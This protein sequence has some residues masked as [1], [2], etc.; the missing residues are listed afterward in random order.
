MQ[1]QGA[2]SFT[3]YSP[4]NRTSVA[5][6]TAW[7]LMQNFTR[8]SKTTRLPSTDEEKAAP[9]HVKEVGT[10]DVEEVKKMMTEGTRKRFEE[11][12]DQ[13]FN[14]KGQETIGYKKSHRV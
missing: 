7:R 5:P 3:A 12:W 13:T 14:P 2:G 8:K 4:S 10:I 9:L 6:R 11:V 1:D